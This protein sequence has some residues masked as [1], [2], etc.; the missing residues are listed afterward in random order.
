MSYSLRINHRP[1]FVCALCPA[2]TGEGP[3][4]Y[5]GEEPI[6]DRCLDA[7]VPDLSALLALNAV[8]RIYVRLLDRDPAEAQ[9][10]LR[11][12][13]I[14]FGDATGHWG[15]PRLIWDPLDIPP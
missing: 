11:P 5:F 10:F 14:E 4:G 6:C 1:G 3:V 7:A 13:L 2:R 15:P 8:A 9:S 12:L